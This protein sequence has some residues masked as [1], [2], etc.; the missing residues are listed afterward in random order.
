M[1]T[2]TFCNGTTRRDFLR[3]GSAGLLG[4]S[5]PQLLA[6]QARASETGSSPRDVSLVF[7][8]L[9]GGL[10]TID[11]FDMKPDAP[12]EFRGEFRPAATNV[13]GTQ[14]C[15][16]LPRLAQRMDKVSLIRNFRHHNS[17]H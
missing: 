6:A 7:L 3:L 12:A 4:L 17:D 14:I 10:S 13:P 5:L 8:F 16:H 2:H 1:P 9:H 15:E 11:S